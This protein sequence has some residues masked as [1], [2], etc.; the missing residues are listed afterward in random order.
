MDAPGA[1]GVE[2]TRRFNQRHERS[3]SRYQRGRAAFLSVNPLCAHCERDGLVI[4]AD[5]VDHITPLKDNPTVEAFWDPDNW[6]GLCRPCHEL[7]TARE[8]ERR[9]PGRDAWAEYT[10]ALASRA[11]P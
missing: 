1:A 5:E 2:M 6:Q 11:T 7:K 9:V 3:T 10:A 4:A 8:N